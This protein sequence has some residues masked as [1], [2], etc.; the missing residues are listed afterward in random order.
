MS[1]I[2]HFFWEGDIGARRLELLQNCVYS[3]SAYNP[4]HTVR[5]VS[6][7]LKQKQFDPRYRILVEGWDRSDFDDIPVSDKIIDTYINADKRT[8]SDFFR[9]VLLYKWGGSYVDTD[10]MAIGPLRGTQNVICRS[11][12][13]HTS[14]YNRIYDNDCIPG[15][16]REIRGY[17]QIPFFPRND[18]WT[19]FTVNNPFIRR[20]FE[21]EKFSRATHPL[22]ILGG[23]SFQSLTNIVGNSDPTPCI[24]GLNLLYLYEDFIV[25][26]SSWD[27]KEGVG[28]MHDLY[29]EVLPDLDKYPWGQYKC[30]RHVA[31][32][33]MFEALKRYPTLSHLWMHSKADKDEWF[34]PLEKEGL[35][36]LS[37]WIYD[38]NRSYMEMLV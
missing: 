7:T 31:R 30:N 34:Q 2:V 17:D 14:F 11:Y 22:D 19:N 33:F 12:D 15:T 1:D 21:N 9:L 35:C 25:G 28:E 6:N 23:T 10:D 27:Y 20:I 18:C 4:T 26:S 29:D 24:F 38:Y 36:S 37:T 16:F 5:L 8:L 13:P 3:T 32:D